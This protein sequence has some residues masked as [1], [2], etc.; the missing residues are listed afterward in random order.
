MKHN[1]EKIRD[2]YVEKGYYLAEV[3]TD[4]K[5]VDD[6]KVDVYFIV[7]EHAKVE[8][9]RINFLG[10][11]AIPTAEL[12][13]AMQ[14]T[15][16]GWL[17]FLTSSGTYREDA[18]DHDLLLLT[19]YYYDKGYINAKL[20]KPVVEISSD[21]HYLYLTLSVEEGEQFRLGKI[22][23]RGEMLRP[24]HE[25]AKMMNVRD[26]DTF[27]RSRLVQDITR[28]NDLYKDAGYA[29]VNVQPLTAIEPNTRTIDVTFD[30]QK[31]NLVYFGRIDIR[32]NTKTRDKVIRREL[33]VF[34]GELYNQTR[35]DR[36]KQAHSVA[37]LLLRKSRRLSTKASEGDPNKIDVSIEVTERATGTFQVGAGFSSVENFIGQAQVAQNNLFGRG[38]S[39]QIQGQISSIRQLFSLR[40]VDPYF[41]DT[42][43]TFSFSAYNSLL[44]YPSFNRTARGGELTF[45]QYVTE[46]K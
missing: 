42:K 26:G 8:V 45:E 33:R 21:K 28:L 29:Y 24:K 14:T 27:N 46:R 3:S 43:L 32:G 35:L 18:F 38:Q 23:F 2:L 11:R 1:V 13:H 20:G 17:S 37:R 5:R 4:I 39:L 10:N 44:Y 34:E 40:F 7:D 9:R 6:T 15:E 31:G 19:A 30:V 25:L 22:D 16:G 41:L 36:S 12:K